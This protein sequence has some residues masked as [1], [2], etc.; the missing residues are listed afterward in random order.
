MT[1]SDPQPMSYE[2]WADKSEQE[3]ASSEPQQRTTIIDKQLARHAAIS[4]YLT[5]SQ[6]GDDIE[7]I[8]NFLLS[9]NAHGY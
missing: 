2:E 8:R 9:P 5:S 6:K 4:T 7:T 3:S 1:S